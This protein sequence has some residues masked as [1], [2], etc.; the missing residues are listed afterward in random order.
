MT[1][2]GSALKLRLDERRRWFA[3]EWFFKWHFIGSPSGVKID[4]FDGRMAQYSGA[5][6]KGSPLEVFWDAIARGARKEVL[7][8]FEWIEDRI[9]RYTRQAAEAAIDESA[10]LLTAFVDALWQAAVEKEQVLSGNGIDFPARREVGSWIGTTREEITQ[11]ADELK[12]AIFPSPFLDHQSSTQRGEARSDRRLAV[13]VVADVVGYSRL[14][15][16]DEDRTLARLRAL[17][18]ELIEPRGAEYRGRI[19]NTAGDSFLMEFDSTALAVDCWLD[20]Q[21]ALAA[22]ETSFPPDRR[23]RLR[24]GMHLGDVIVD[25]MDLKGDT[26]N[27]AARLQELAEPGGLCVSAAIHDGISNKPHS[28]QIEKMGIQHLKNIA[29]P[30]SAF[31]IMRADARDRLTAKLLSALA[32]D[33]PDG[34]G[35]KN[36]AIEYIRDLLPQVGAQDLHD[37]AYALAERGLV[38]MTTYFGGE[39]HLRLTLEFYVQTDY[40]VM[41]W[42]TA[43][44]AKAIAAQMLKSGSGRAATAHEA[45]GWEP[46]RFNPA[47]QYVVQHIPS[48]WVSQE[49]SRQYPAVS[50]LLQPETVAALRRFTAN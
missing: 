17:R 48:Q 19:F 8:Q 22:R 40:P 26:V 46:R 47:F 9:Q 18:S 42:S 10:I 28:L 3:N 14:T 44:D 4:T 50:I 20:I 11:L 30:I 16:V 49:R 25:G 5:P 24:V 6:F 41:G 7:S 23:I 33:C 31:S 32:K 43:D 29:R 13:I 39:W 12:K 21:T 34:L 1:P 35:R 27:I 15:S 36:Y 45:S 2:V 38:T 37:E